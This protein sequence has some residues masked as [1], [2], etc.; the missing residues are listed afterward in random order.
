VSIEIR[1][2][3]FD[4]GR[5]PVLDSIDADAGAGRVTALLGPNAA[6]KSTLLRCAIGVLRPRR[7]AVRVGGVPATRLR[8]RDLARRLAYVA[9]RSVVSARL[10]VREVVALGR[11]ALEPDERRVVTAIERLELSDVA[12][13]PYPALSVGQQQ[14][15]ALARAVAQIEPDG[16]LVLDEPTAAMDLR[17]ARDGGTLLRE[18]ADGGATVLIAMHD[19]T[20]AAELADDA[21]LLAPGGRLA[22]AGPADEVLEIDRLREVFEVEFERVERGDGRLSLLPSRP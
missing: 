6:G 8:G 15:V 19:I 14:R 20:A 17:H 22:A 12:D 21:W 18:L 11:Y 13:R 3:A 1:Q 4:Y 5:R 9:Q 10:T 7:G 2:L 16:H